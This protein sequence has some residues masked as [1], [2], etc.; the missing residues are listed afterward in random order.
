MNA[1]HYPPLSANSLFHFTRSIDHLIDILKNEF[2]PHFCLEDFNVLY[3][4]PQK[5]KALEYAIPITCYCDIP[6]SQIAFHLSI[7]G[8][9]GI[10]MSKS[11]GK[12]KGIN[13]I[14]Y[15]YPGSLITN[16]LDAMMSIVDK[17]I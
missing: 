8:D 9:Y 11:W 5:F 7:Y 12:K 14:L 2:K 16:H 6:L 1:S 17:G 13:P 3:Q 4:N 15:V 10:G